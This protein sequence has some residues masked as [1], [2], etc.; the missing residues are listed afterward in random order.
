M[1]KFP[2]ASRWKIKHSQVIHPYK[3]SSN[4]KRISNMDHLSPICENGTGIWR[5]WRWG[6]FES[7]KGHQTT[8]N[9]EGKEIPLSIPKPP[10]RK[11][12][13][14]AEQCDPFVDQRS[15]QIRMQRSFSGNLNVIAEDDVVSKHHSHFP[16]L[17]NNTTS[18]T[19]T[20]SCHDDKHPSTP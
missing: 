13:Y 20:G 15:N 19:L 8:I 2:F 16:K 18:D 4:P 10:R 14:I 3:R 17:V 1:P 12:P 11:K 7:Q 9:P 5:K 6:E